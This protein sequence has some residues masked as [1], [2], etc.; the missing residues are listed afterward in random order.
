VTEE[1]KKQ[2]PAPGGEEPASVVAKAIQDFIARIPET[3]EPAAAQPVDRARSIAAAAALKAAATSAALAIPPGPLGLLTIIPDLLLIWSIQAKMVAD[4]AGA[5]GKTAYLNQEQMLYC[6]FRHAASQAVRDLVVRV[7]ER[8]LIRR[9]TLR[10]LQ[11]AARRIGVK[12]AQRLI[13]KSLSRWVPIVGALGVGA[14]AYY[15]T[16]Q[17]AATALELFQ[18]EIDIEGDP[19]SAA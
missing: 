7:G 8:M 3:D 16:G 10:G 12:I 9:G 18:R 13:G 11:S 5:F 14:Y 2:L 15:D 17:V 4:I 19:R 6:L 1:D